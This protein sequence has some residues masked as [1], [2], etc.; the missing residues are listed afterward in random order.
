[1]ENLFYNLSEA[2]FTKGRK[3]LIWILAGFFFIMGLWN[4]FSNLVLGIGTF[5]LNLALMPF[6]ISF[7]ITL[8]A[9]FAT[10]KRKDHYF[11]IDDTKI[12]FRNG[13]LN[14]KKHSFLWSNI[15][16]VHLPVKQKKALLLFKDGTSFKI[17]LMWIEKKKSII[18]RKHLYYFAKE[19]SIKLQR[20]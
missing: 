4:L 7:F 8:F 12:E 17:N 9:A 16:E 5:S 6:M 13:I 14:P 2:E 15:T 1:M 10:I 3:I 18:I 11:C 19:K 20:F